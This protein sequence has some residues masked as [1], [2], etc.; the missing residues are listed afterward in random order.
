MFVVE[1][2]RRFGQVITAANYSNH[3]ASN[4]GKHEAETVLFSPIIRAT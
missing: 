2:T 3:F 4:S 1:H